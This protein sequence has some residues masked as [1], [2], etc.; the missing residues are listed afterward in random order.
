MCSFGKSSVCLS[1]SVYLSVC[2]PNL[3]FSMQQEELISSFSWT[4]RVAS[5]EAEDTNLPEVK[6]GQVRGEKEGGR[7]E[8]TL[9]STVYY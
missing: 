4:H 1:Q 8:D 5:V 6:V 2:L 3:E 9:L 7:G